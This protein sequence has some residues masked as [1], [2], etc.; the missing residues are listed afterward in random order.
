MAKFLSLANKMMG[1]SAGQVIVNRLTVMASGLGIALLAPTILQPIEQGYFFTFMSLAAL[2]GL[3]ELGITSLLIQ[4]FAHLKGELLHN[5][6]Q[7]SAE[8]TLRASGVYTFAETYFKKAGL[9]FLVLVGCGG[10]AFFAY[11]QQDVGIKVWLAPW[12]IL[13]IATA[14]S[15][16]NL[17]NFCAVE[18]FGSLRKSYRIRT[19]SVILL[20][21]IFFAGML[22]SGGLYAHPIALLISQIYCAFKLRHELRALNV[23]RS[24]A[25]HPESVGLHGIQATQRKFAVSAV[26]GFFT[27]NSI[28]PYAFHFFGPVV[29]GQ[30]G[31]T[32]SMFVA[33]ASLAM[34]FSTADAPVYGQLLSQGRTNDVF[35]A[36]RKNITYSLFA[37]G[38]MCIMLIAVNL[39]LNA[40]LPTYAAKV[41]GLSAFLY[42][43]VMIVA[44][45]SLTTVSTVLRAFKTEVLMWPSVIAALVSLILQFFVEATPPHYFL[46]MALYNGLIF[47]PYAF[48]LMLQRLN[49][50][51]VY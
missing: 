49:C 1:T 18:G 26:A 11:S 22:L 38:V 7:S 14:L 10:T 31:L 29:A 36:W 20:F 34:A 28:T 16:Y 9:L 4:H 51:R 40:F 3:F 19:E 5:K 24:A 6:E 35:F 33:A 43:T 23:R 45:T 44:N 50:R 46:G 12:L 37:A 17:S 27:A 48:Y 41:L 30:V 2:Q 25:F 21:L 15:L 8:L 39:V 32:V 42:L 47:L 13:I